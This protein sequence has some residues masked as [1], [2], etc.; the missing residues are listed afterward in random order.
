MNNLKYSAYF[1]DLLMVIK[2]LDALP[3]RFLKQIRSISKKNL[4]KDLEK[5]MIDIPIDYLNKIISKA[6]KIDKEVEKLIISE[7]IENV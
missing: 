4:K 2:E 3:P 1:K 7:E 6:K 5:L